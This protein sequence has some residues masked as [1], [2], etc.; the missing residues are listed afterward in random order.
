MSGIESITEDISK[1]PETAAELVEFNFMLDSL[2]KRV[3]YL[4][5]RL[6]YLRELYDLMGEFN[7]PIPPDDMSEFLGK[8]VYFIIEGKKLPF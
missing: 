7:C 4:E 3:A 2:E 8:Y 5:E 6:D 1:D